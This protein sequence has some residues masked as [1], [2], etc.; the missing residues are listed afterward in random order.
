[1]QEVFNHI[2]KRI[3]SLKEFY[4]N[5]EEDWDLAHSQAYDEVIKIVKQA[6]AEYNCG[7][8]PVESGI[9]PEENTGVDVTVE[10]EH[11]EESGNK[12]YR[13]TAESWLQEGQWIIKKNPYHPKVVAWKYPTAPYQPKTSDNGTM[14]NIIID[15][16]GKLYPFLERFKERG[17]KLKIL[18]LN[19]MPASERFIPPTIA[20]EEV[21]YEFEC[22]NPSG[23]EIKEELD[24]NI[25]KI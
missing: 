14:P 18:N 6:A 8:I 23:P 10:E 24:K 11:P 12:L 4:M 13:Y 3:E 21:P 19:D 25:R 7:W 9:L 1:M 20:S 16:A 2:I 5:Y 15:R 22:A 17:Y